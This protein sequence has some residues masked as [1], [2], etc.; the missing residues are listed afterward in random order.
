[1][2]L[3][4]EAS[5]EDIANYMGVDVDKLNKIRESVEHEH[6]VS[7]DQKIIDDEENIYLLDTIKDERTPEM[8]VEEKQLREILTDVINGLGE[9][10]RLVITL[11]Y[12][13]DLSM[14]EI[15]KILGCT[16]SR[17][18]QIHTQVMKKI[19]ERIKV[20][21]ETWEVRGERWYV[22]SFSKTTHHPHSPASTSKNHFKN[23]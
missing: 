1:M 11:Y 6:M 17:V 18:S 15:G 4:R 13:E 10:E 22:K 9:R 7:L 14:A 19:R 5:L 12:Y 21:R 3:N 23:F 8:Y 2:E 16:E 20:R